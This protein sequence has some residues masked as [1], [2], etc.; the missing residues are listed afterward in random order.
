M[1]NVNPD[2]ANKALI[3]SQKDQDAAAEPEENISAIDTNGNGQ[4]TIAE[5]KA[6]GFKMPIT[7][8]YWMTGMG[9]E[10]RVSP[11]LSLSVKLGREK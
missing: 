8:D 6:A 5:A 2:E 10:I 7:R 3:E 1:Y 11:A 9:T 4:I